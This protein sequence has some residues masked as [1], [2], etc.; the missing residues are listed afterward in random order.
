[1]NTTVKEEYRA[2][3]EAAPP[4]TASRF[5][6]AAVDGYNTV[7]EGLI[8][9]GLFVLS[10]GPSLLLWAAILFFPARWAWKKLRR[11]AEEPETSSV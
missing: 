1:V 5:R 11:K 3:L 2:K 9:V 4:S 10:A 7:V 6:N 8:D